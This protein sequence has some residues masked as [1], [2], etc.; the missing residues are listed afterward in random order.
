MARI[1]TIILSILLCSMIAGQP[2]EG[3]QTRHS[4]K[5][6][7]VQHKDKDRD[8][9][10]T[11]AELDRL[12]SIEPSPG[13]NHDPLLFTSGASDVLIGYDSRK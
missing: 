13:R 12:F 9:G 5:A 1:S 10:L 2:S 3:K 4:K 6:Q 8:P 7:K 11:K